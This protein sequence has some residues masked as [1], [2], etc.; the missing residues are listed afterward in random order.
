MTAPAS[1]EEALAWLRD[2]A[3]ELA[4][5][6]T[7]LH[8]HAVQP[9]DLLGAPK[10][11]AAFLRH[12]DDGPY[13]TRQAPREVSCPA[14]HP[15]RRYGEP[16]CAMCEDTGYWMTATDVYAHPLRAALSTL[17]RARSKLRPHPRLV[18]DALLREWCDPAAA[19]LRLPGY[20]PDDRRYV[21]AIRALYDGFSY[22]AMAPARRAA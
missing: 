14:F 16:L 13:A 12:V 3:Q 2:V 11:A 17:S 1:L 5:V 9:T 18:I 21:S 7:R 6:P 20:A 19:A 8:E 15:R 10:M 4:D 22:T